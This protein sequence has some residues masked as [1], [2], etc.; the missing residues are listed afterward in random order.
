[1]AKPTKCVS[2][3]EARKLQDNW[4]A[5]RSTHIQR[6]E[7]SEDCREFVYSVKELEEYLDYVKEESTKQGIDAPGIRIYFGAY[8]TEKSDKATI[9][10]APTEGGD[11]EDDNNYNIDPFNFGTGGWP[12]KT[13]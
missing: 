5:T 8:N 4:V 2:V 11:S 7:G 6:A 3:E 1:M 9:F 10:L 12:P 13:Y